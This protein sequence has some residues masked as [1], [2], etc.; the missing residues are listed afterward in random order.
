[1]FAIHRTYNTWKNFIIILEITHEFV[2][3]NNRL[4]RKLGPF[5]HSD[6]KKGRIIVLAGAL[7]RAGLLPWTQVIIAA[8]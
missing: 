2:W 4:F 8:Q 1:M 7:E 3:C 5:L 6:G